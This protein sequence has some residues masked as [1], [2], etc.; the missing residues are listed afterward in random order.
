[1]VC[2]IVLA[3]CVVLAALW[4]SLPD[5]DTLHTR[6]RA[7]ATQILD[8]KG[9]LLYEIFDPRSNDAGRHT[10]VPLARMSRWLPAAVIAV[11]DASFYDNPGVDLLGI[12]RALWINLLGGEALAGGSTITQQLAR[13]LLLEPEERQQRTVLRKLRESLLAWRIAMRYSKD[14]VLTLYLNEAYFGNLS[15]G[16]EAAAR[17]YFGRSAAELNLAEAA[18]L[19][20]L[21]QSPAAYDPFNDLP[22]ALRRQRI[23]LDL[24]RKTGV[25]SEDERIAALATPIALAPSPHPIRAPHF[26]SYVRRELELRFGSEQLVRGGLIVTTTLDLSANEAAQEIV[27]TQLE[28]LGRANADMPDHNAA[29]AAVIVLDARSGAIRVMLGSPDYFDS[30]ISGAV[31]ASVALRQ[32]GSAF[33]PLTYAAA[34]SRPQRFTAATPLIDVR[35]AFDTREG[36]PYVPVNYDRRHHGVLNVRS[37]LATSNNVAAVTLLDEL[38]LPPV[39]SLAGELGIRTLTRPTDYGLALTLGGGEVRLLEL[40]AAY[41]AFARGGARLDPY[42]ISSVRD[43]SGRLLFERE[44]DA[45]I[46]VLDPRVAW[47]ISDIL[48]DNDARAPAF[49]QNSVLHLPWPAAVKTGTTQDFRDNWAI[50]Y[51]S[52][53]IAGV[54]VGNASGAPM[55]GVTGLTGAGPIW[56][57]IM[58]LIHGERTPQLLPQPAGLARARVCTLSGML[59]SPACML[60]RDEWFIDGSAPTDQD[61]WHRLDN[62]R[63]VFDL[64]AEVRPWAKA[65]GWPLFAGTREPQAEPATATRRAALRFLQPDPNVVLRIDPTLPRAVQRVP[66]SVQADVDNADVLGIDIVHNGSALLARLPPEGGAVFWPLVPGVHDFEARALLPGG[67]L[68]AR[69]SVRITV[70]E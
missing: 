41:G 22:L 68:Q 16:V 57:G 10:P 32:P 24:M 3:P 54:W 49:G 58:L 20:G 60:T 67:R 8:R 70:I 63:I 45:T 27:R 38:G 42:A 28:Q 14:E 17:A 55:Q 62:G 56:R 4:L 13:M 21:P 47:L 66:L 51:S 64:P 35:R 5:V 65:Q 26:V 34:L 39:L 53:A 33:K 12:A 29:N 52:E 19:A 23:V 1:M 9:R 15:Y 69:A 46:Q 18:L 11:E 36:L 2:A 30:A 59:P 31:N 25:I 7:P 50:G 43:R 40:S 37:A 44:S 48:S 6:A 61:T